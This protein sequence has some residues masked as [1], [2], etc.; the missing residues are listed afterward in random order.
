MQELPDG[1]EYFINI[2]N[3]DSKVTVDFLKSY[4]DDIKIL[5][6]FA[7]PNKIG[8]YELIFESK[9]DACKFIEKGPG[10]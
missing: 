6:I 9:E 10:V 5:N 4:Y 2:F 8:N 3:V 1:N 7:N